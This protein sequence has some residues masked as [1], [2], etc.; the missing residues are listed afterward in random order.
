MQIN[1][2][3]MHAFGGKSDLERSFLIL[4]MGYLIVYPT[5]KHIC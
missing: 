3:L 2:L 5:I 4:M 1:A